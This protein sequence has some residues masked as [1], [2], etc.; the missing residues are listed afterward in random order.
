M[1]KEGELLWT[2]RPEFAQASNLA[3]YMGW[4]KRT[5]DKDFADYDALWRWSVSDIEGF[6][7]S[8]WEYFEVHSERPYYRVL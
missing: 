6:W 2:P 1:V 3:R 4:L 8:I 7:A 5:R